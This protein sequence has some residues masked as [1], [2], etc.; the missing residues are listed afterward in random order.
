MEG[1]VRAQFINPFLAFVGNKRCSGSM[2]NEALHVERVL[3]LLGRQLL[4]TQC[5]AELNRYADSRNSSLY[6]SGFDSHVIVLADFDERKN[7]RVGTMT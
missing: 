1:H 7:G 6:E 4:T 2:R 3:G 5:N